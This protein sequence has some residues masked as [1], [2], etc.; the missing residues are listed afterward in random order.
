MKNRI[1]FI[2]FYLIFTFVFTSCVFAASDMNKVEDKEQVKIE[3]DIKNKEKTKEESKKEE[4]S[5]EDSKKPD[6]QKQKDKEKNDAAEEKP[7]DLVYNI[8]VAKNGSITTDHISEAT[9][10]GIMEIL[11]ESNKKGTTYKTIDQ[12]NTIILHESYGYKLTKDVENKILNKYSSK[13]PNIE[14]MVKNNK[15]N[16]EEKAQRN[17]KLLF[18]GVVLWLTLNRVPTTNEVIRKERD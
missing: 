12:D 8:V 14:I 16:K 2:L 3:K 10:N 11:D 17:K 13:L 6:N 7:E 15:V 4:K 9:Y 1:K 18:L 5:V